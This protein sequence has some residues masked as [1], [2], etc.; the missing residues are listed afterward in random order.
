M[1]RQALI[2]VDMLNDFIDPKGTLYCGQAGEA[3]VPFIKER[4]QAARTHDDLVI[5]VTDS[6]EEDDVEFRRYDR[7]AVAG[8]W[9]GEIIP[10]L[11][12]AA[13]EPV[14]CKKTL[15]SFHGT[16]L[17]QLLAEAAVKT[18]EVVGVCTS[19]CVMDLVGDLAARN[20]GIVVPANGVAD[21][22]EEF[23]E[24]ALRRMARVYG[25]EVS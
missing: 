7:H 24:F 8:T 6:H 15:N 23:H 19:I 3:I 1:A 18:V 13:G 12:P 25:A 5:F 20:Y 17:E 22:D 16:K 10:D 14:V 21:F 2:I 4:L 9:G 11:S